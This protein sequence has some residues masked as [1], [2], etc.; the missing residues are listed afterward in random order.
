LR[1]NK[2]LPGLHLHEIEVQKNLENPKQQIQVSILESRA[3][4][5]KKSVL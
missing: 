2:N 5:F 4:F 3:A 1:P